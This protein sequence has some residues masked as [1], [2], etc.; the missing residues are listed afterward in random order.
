MS[1]QNNDAFETR[2][3]ARGPEAAP[4]CC[5][6]AIDDAGNQGNLRADDGEF[7]VV[8]RRELQQRVDVVRLDGDITDLRFRFGTRVARRHEHLRDTRRLRAFPRERVF[9]AAATDNHH[10][11]RTG[12]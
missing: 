2:S 3:R 5:C 6:K 9:A 12:T 11:H 4:S 10:L 8:A 7:Y 1:E